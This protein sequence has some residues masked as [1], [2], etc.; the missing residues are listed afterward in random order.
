[1]GM[2]KQD[3]PQAEL[4]KE[5]LVHS[6]TV[7]P[8]EDAVETARPS[9]PNTVSAPSSAA[10]YPE[11]TRH[12][13][14]NAAPAQ[15]HTLELHPQFAAQAGNK[16]VGDRVQSLYFYTY[17]ILLFGAFIGWYVFSHR[18]K[19]RSHDIPVVLQFIGYGTALLPV[20]VAP[21]FLASKRVPRVKAG[22]LVQLVGYLIGFLT[23]F[24]IIVNNFSYFFGAIGLLTLLEAAFWF[25]TRSVLNDVEG[26][27]LTD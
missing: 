3:Q 2:A 26:L 23:A 25:W 20:L 19:F 6:K 21:L 8:P 1:M 24:V 9:T 12:L 15:L 17:A 14:G 7:H 5:M 4:P 13:P 11:A 22:L 16:R 27:P 18:T 10:I